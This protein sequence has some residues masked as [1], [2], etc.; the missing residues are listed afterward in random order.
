MRPPRRYRQR[1][2]F[3]V[4]QGRMLR[5]DPD[6]RNAK[7]RKARLHQRKLEAEAARV[8]RVILRI[9]RNF[10][11][12]DSRTMLAS[13]RMQTSLMARAAMA[14]VT[15]RWNLL[16]CGRR[17]T[18]TRARVSLRVGRAVHRRKQTNQRDGER[19]EDRSGRGTRP[20]PRWQ[21]GRQ[22]LRV[23]SQLQYDDT[24]LDVVKPSHKLIGA[25]TTNS[26]S[27]TNQTACPNRCQ[28]KSA[29][30]F[31]TR[32]SVWKRRTFFSAGL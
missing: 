8:R 5:Q 10:R 4:E 27:L 22:R 1:P 23:I 15:A 16:N 25:E 32:G 12:S 13:R 7:Q 26:Q 17:S 14:R 31:P 11:G 18:D 30:L 6:L 29:G 19:N 20:E 21:R 9:L 2:R 28:T 3:R 24:A